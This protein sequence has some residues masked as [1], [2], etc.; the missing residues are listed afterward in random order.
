MHVPLLWSVQCDGVH[1]LTQIP[2]PGEGAY[3]EA[4]KTLESHYSLFWEHQS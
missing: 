2:Q 3:A 4:E 1:C